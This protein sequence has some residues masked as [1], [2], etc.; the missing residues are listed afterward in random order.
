[1]DVLLKSTVIIISRSGKLKL[2]LPEN[3]IC[4][5]NQSH[6]KAPDPTF[7]ICK[8]FQLELDLVK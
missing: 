7:S 3:G 5:A 1:M 8:R 2:M 6:S 4:L